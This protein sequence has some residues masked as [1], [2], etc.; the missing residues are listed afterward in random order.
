MAHAIGVRTPYE[1]IPATV[2]AW[3]ER[4]LGS[5]VVSAKTQQGGFSPGTAARLVTASGR[6]AFVK[7]V[8]P[9]LNPDTP[10]LF[11]NEITAMR[12]VSLPHAP[13][14]YGTYDDGAWVGLMLEDID[15]ALPVHPWRQGDADRVLEALAEVTA[16]LT[17][18]PWT[19]APV[20]A[21]RSGG[22]LS[23][24][25]QVIADRTPVPDW[26]RGREEELAVIAADGV[27]ALAKGNSLVHWDLRADNILLT[28]DRVVF[29]D[30]TFTSRAADWADA[31][32]V[33]AEMRSSVRLPQ[34]GDDP[35]ITGFLAGIA[36]GLLW[37]SQQAAPPG[38][39]TIRAWQRG[40]ADLYL[41][42][43][44]ERLGW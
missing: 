41:D 26:A 30:W 28:G 20:A 7:A 29:V 34:L 1:A 19:A 8:G 18:S 10:A 40:Q 16:A 12:A 11:R 21:E 33:H 5:S 17:P 2:R 38:L 25:G 32:F 4:E 37:G 22:F 27:E 24:W 39:P 44:R 15:G 13:T 31:V 43:L 9:E 14:L 36:G 6:R 42:W 23:R 3:V 35:G